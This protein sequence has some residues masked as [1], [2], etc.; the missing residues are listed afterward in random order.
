MIES[1]PETRVMCIGLVPCPCFPYRKHEVGAMFPT[2]LG[3][4]EVVTVEVSIRWTSEML[5]ARVN[6]VHP[7]KG[8]PRRRAPKRGLGR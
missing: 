5:E 3:V 6:K 1:S 2:T 7:I 8:Q 4:Y